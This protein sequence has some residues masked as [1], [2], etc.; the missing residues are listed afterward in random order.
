M[1]GGGSLVVRARTSSSSSFSSSSSSSAAAAAA[2][3]AASSAATTSAASNGEE[4]YL[5]VSL[6]KETMGCAIYNT[7][8]CVL[9]VTTVNSWEGDG[10]DDIDVTI[11][12]LKKSSDERPTCVL[13]SHRLDADIAD[14]LRHEPTGRD[15]P[16]VVVKSSLFAR[17]LSTIATLRVA[18]W[19][20]DPSA[21][22][23]FI[24]TLEADENAAM[25]KAA[26][27][28]CNWLARNAAVEQMDDGARPVSIVRVVHFSPFSFVQ[29]DENTLRSLAIFETE[30]HPSA[31][32]K[33]RTRAKE[34]FSIVGLFGR[35]V[36]PMG[37]R[38]FKQWCR[39]P[40]KE[41]EA[42]RNRF[43]AVD[44]LLQ[45]S[46]AEGCTSLRSHLRKV[47]D[48]PRLLLRIK[49]VQASVADWGA[50]T[51]SLSASFEVKT[52]VHLML[53][54]ESSVTTED[55]A[56]PGSGGD[57]SARGRGAQPSLICEIVET[58]DWNQLHKCAQI[59][60]ESIDMQRSFESGR[61][62][63]ADGVNQELDRLRD[64]QYGLDDLLRKVDAADFTPE[65]SSLIYPAAYHHRAHHGFLVELVFPSAQQALDAMG[66]LQDPAS[67]AK[68]RRTLGLPDDYE[69]RFCE[70]NAVFFIT[71]RTKELWESVGDI[72]GSVAKTEQELARTIEDFI[73][74]REHDLLALT[75]VIARL[76]TVLS[77]ALVAAEHNMVRPTMRADTVLLIKN[78]RHPLQEIS[79][80]TFIPNDTLLASTKGHSPVAIV[81]G[82][83]CSGKSVYLKQVGIIVFLA[84]IGCFVPAEAAV[85][86][87][88]DRIFTRIHSMETV[89]VAQSSFVID[90]KQIR[91]IV[92]FSTPRSLL[93]VD[94]FGK[95][96]NAV[97]G[98]ALLAAF[99][100]SITRDAA[101]RPKAIISTHFSE[102][103]NEEGCLLNPHLISLF[104][105]TVLQ[106]S[107]EIITP[108]FKL[109]PGSTTKSFGLQ[110]AKW[111]G[112]DDAVI[113]RAREV[114]SALGSGTAVKP[115]ESSDP[116]RR[117]IEGNNRAL[118]DLFAL[119]RNWNTCSDEQLASLF[120]LLRRQTT[121]SK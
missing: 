80:K 84:H 109:K 95:G 98:I 94:E 110:C 47:R 55:E 100:N 82:P 25:A 15:L 17:P 87:I 53:Q 62:I 64:L 28:L 70:Q 19:R 91:T 44:F 121:M 14:L 7:L 92:K 9:E 88:V 99:I 21:R 8:T 2:A 111:A 75:N 106:E 48:V 51:K 104:R 43:D 56:A 36:T 41:P 49:N 38:R 68:V 13:C 85:V 118:V 61:V 59:M 6:E 67:V 105:M 60:T 18:E 20:S 58:V 57:G 93:L 16:L 83:N 117:Q 107:E 5:C 66:D 26:G 119:E 54:Y 81:T 101:T 97:D 89:S 34:G 39:K 3:A 4:T 102:V 11:E 33:K 96:T 29:I 12:A 35:C 50:L 78:G 113:A 40:L 79:V 76:D 22:T 73:I 114:V 74:A 10:S 32:L 1:E 72:D 65:K 103:F 46:L 86:G 37:K 120:A 71:R 23:T 90:C 69:P 112:V 45:P 24:E 77:F 116:V 63:V 30:A 108:L 115:L 52:V 42:L 27:G 31:S